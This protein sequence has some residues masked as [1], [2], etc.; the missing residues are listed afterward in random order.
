V[1]REDESKRKENRGNVLARLEQ[2]RRDREPDESSTDRRQAVRAATAA[3][4]E[5]NWTRCEKQM[6]RTTGNAPRVKLRNKSEGPL[7]DEQA[8]TREKE[9]PSPARPPA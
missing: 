4:W 2:N 6:L 9:D 1:T 5:R 7:L 3:K 8:R